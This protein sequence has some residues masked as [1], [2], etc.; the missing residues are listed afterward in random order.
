[1]KESNFT[2]NKDSTILFY[3][4]GTGNT[5]LVANKIA[6]NLNIEIK[7]MEEDLIFSNLIN[8]KETIIIMYPVYYSTPPILVR[9]FI[10]KYDD[11]FENKQVMSIVSQM[12]FSGDGAY[13]LSEYLPPSSKL[14]Y[15]RHINMPSNISNLPVIPYL[16]KIFVNLR[17]NHALKKAKKISNEIKNNNLRTQGGTKLGNKFGLSQRKGGLE[18][19]NKNKSSVWVDDSCIGCGICEESCPVNNFYVENNKAESKG[20]CILCTRCENLCPKKSIRVFINKE[21]KHQYKIPEKFLNN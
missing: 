9:E 10:K 2:F 3:F 12:G 21:V 16:E 14:I 19:E 18:K 6:K 17:I 15:S 5:K 13:V 7:S 1:M 8:K 20:Q 4:S 11:C